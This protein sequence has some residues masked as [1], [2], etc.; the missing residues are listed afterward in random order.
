[1][2][3][4]DQFEEDILEPQVQQDGDGAVEEAL[5]RGDLPLHPD[6]DEPDFP[7]DVTD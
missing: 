6:V 2:L 7:V 3:V 5:E 1:V 4:D